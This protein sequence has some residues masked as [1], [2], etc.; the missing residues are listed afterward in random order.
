MA[1]LLLFGACT[2][3]PVAPAHAGGRV[4][5]LRS[6]V[7]NARVDTAGSTP[8]LPPVLDALCDALQRAAVE[9]TGAGGESSGSGRPEWGTW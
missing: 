2:C 3:W 5:L 4:R 9:S 6:G 1:G 7:A 8:G